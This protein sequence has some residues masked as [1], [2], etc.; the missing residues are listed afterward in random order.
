MDRSQR[1]NDLDV[2]LSEMFDGLRVFAVG[3]VVRALFTGNAVSDVDLM[4]AGATPA[5]MEER[6][7]RL[8]E[9]SNFPVFLDDERREVALARTERSTGDGHTDFEVHADP[10]VTVEED[11]ERRDFTVNAMAVSLTEAGRFD[12]GELVDPFGGR[13]DFEAGV[14]RMVRPESFAEDPLRILRMAR[15][16]ARLNLEVDEETMAAAREHVDGLHDLPRER[17]GMEVVKAMKQ[18]EQPS[19]F[20]RVLDDADALEVVLPELAA[21]QDVPAGPPDHHREGDAFAHTMQV[22]DEMAALRPGE[23]RAAFAAMAHDLGKGLTPEERLPSHP[24][25]HVR[26]VDLAE[27]IQERLVLTNELRGV[28]ASASRF[29]M[30][31]HNLDELRESTL[32]DM[33]E[34]LRDDYEVSN[35]GDEPVVAHVRLDE[36]IDLAVAD[37]RGREPASEFDREAARER[38]D[39]A[40]AV[41]DEI[42]GAQIQEQFDPQDGEH[43][44]E[45]LLQERIRALRERLS[46]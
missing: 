6:G 33:V 9:A 40:L 29:H 43:V 16:A 39:A 7:F 15:F 24:K 20:F 38:F 17:W 35:P 2:D 46:A 19:G 13:E 37:G 18:A 4:V 32:L 36:L 10:S 41:L 30:R 23:P 31:M 14:L 5:E 25:H 34:R 11:L 21:L 42:D 26:G 28:M 8:I 1:L 44:G 27:D 22:V 3:G 12:A 45:L